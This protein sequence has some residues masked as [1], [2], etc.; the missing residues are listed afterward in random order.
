MKLKH[1]GLKRIQIIRFCDSI[2]IEIANNIELL[3]YIF[4]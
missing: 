3:E 1:P 4:V 2:K